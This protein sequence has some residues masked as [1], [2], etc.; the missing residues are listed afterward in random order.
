MP[1]EIVPV[2]KAKAIPSAEQG[3][4]AVQS[5][6][7]PVGVIVPPPDIR[8]IAE[9][10]AQFVAKNGAEFEKKILANEKKNP[11]FRFLTPNDPY[12]AYYQHKLAEFREKP[13]GTGQVS[14]GKASA[15]V[16][17]THV[18]PP[19]EEV[20]EPEEELYTVHIPEEMAA[21][22]LDVIKLTAQYVACNGNSFLTGLTQREQANPL[23][24]FLKPSHSLHPIYLKFK[25]AYTH[26]MEPGESTRKKLQEDGKDRDRVLDRILKRLEWNVQK[27]KENKAA[28]EEAEKERIAMAEIDWLD[29]AVVAT[30]DFEEE[31]DED[32][33]LPSTLEDVLRS[34]HAVLKLEEPGTQKSSMDEEERRMVEEASAM[35]VTPRP[36]E[37]GMKIVKDYKPPAA[38]GGRTGSSANALKYAISP[39]TGEMIPINEMAEHMRYSLIDPKFREQ[40][41]SM[42]SKIKGS[43]QASDDEI[44]KN[45][46]H[47]AGTRP[48]IFSTHDSEITDALQKEMEKSRAPMAPSQLASAPSN[49]PPP[50]AGPTRSAPAAEKPTAPPVP[51]PPSVPPP[52]P[53]SGPP[54]PPPVLPSMP[55]PASQKAPDN[56][57]SSPNLVHEPGTSMAPSLE[58]ESEDGDGASLVN[59]KK[60][61]ASN[62][63]VDQTENS[64]KRIRIEKDQLVS[65]ADFLS[66]HPG[67]C[68]CHV[69][70]AKVHEMPGFEGQVLQV[71]VDSLATLVS[72]LK[73]S[74]SS[75]VD[76]PPSKQK[77]EIP[78][79]GALRDNISLAYY[80]I[81]EEVILH[82]VPK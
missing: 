47:L 67:P 13:G 24:S 30:V 10:T 54:P 11:K 39:I 71:H 65:K 2:G 14:A 4:Q 27:K 31:E 26:V 68:T 18:P 75:Q 50:Q 12:N 25:E 74:I 16:A 20:E 40:R 77:L 45:I 3:T 64:P 1:G 22:E 53:P 8:A 81:S 66:S 35:R 51:P 28:E 58:R 82:L 46:V 36:P 79:L 9:K 69:Q 61:G 59:G 38:S 23:F 52:P 72:S 78:G 76:I 21:L 41:Q 62:A 5:H 55:Q 43:I 42:L 34:Q 63:G 80:N 48:D 37:P 29:F 44:A 32:L 6:A 70:V 19:K 17:P 7:L 49:P 56:L 33:P 60:R 15:P 57:K 73:H